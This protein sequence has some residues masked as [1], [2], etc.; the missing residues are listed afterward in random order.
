M[1]SFSIPS[2][3]KSP[4]SDVSNDEFLLLDE[5]D[6]LFIVGIDFGTTKCPTELSYGDDGKI[7][8][9]FDVPPNASSVLWFKLLLF[10][11]EDINNDTDVSEYLV[12]AREFLSR[13]NKIA[14]D[15]VSNFLGALWKYT[16]TKIVRARGQMVVDA[17]VFRV[18][19]TVPAIWKGYAR[20]AMHKAAD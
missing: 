11:E 8:W 15:V 4:P 12:S 20:Q 19:I 13:I 9:G 2:R 6:G 14:I 1:L 10:R 5:Q 17:L 7:Y 16:I 3:P 18:V